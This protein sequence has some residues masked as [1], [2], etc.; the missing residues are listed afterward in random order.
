MFLRPDFDIKDLGLLKY[1][2]GAGVNS[3]MSES[4]SKTMLYIY[5]MILG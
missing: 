2:L 4:L 5:S 3:K 1:L